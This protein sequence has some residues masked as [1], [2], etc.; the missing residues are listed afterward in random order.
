MTW[1]LESPV[2]ETGAVFSPEGDRIAFISN[3][4]GRSEVYVQAFDARERPH[5]T[6]D[7]VRLSTDGAV[8]VRWRADGR[9]ICYMGIDGVL[10][11]VPVSTHPQFRAG[12]P[13]PL[14]RIPVAAR[15]ALAT[16]FGLDV[17][18]DGGRFLLPVVQE[19]TTSHLVVMLGW[20]SFLKRTG[21]NS[22]RD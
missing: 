5:L 6:G 7:P 18:A 9:E 2:N 11:G 20:E 1:I 10:Y 17:S 3:E 19:P 16:A 22:A 8:L 14:F 21:T 4:S 15:A 12:A 13:A